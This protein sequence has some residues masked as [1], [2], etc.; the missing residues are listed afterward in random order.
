MRYLNLFILLFPLSADAD[1][2]EKTLDVV[3]FASGVVVSFVVHEVSHELTARA[4][5]EKLDWELNGFAT[6][7]YC[8]SPCEHI[9]KIAIAGNLSTAILGESLMYL[10]AKYKY[11][12][13]V[14]GMQ[15]YNVE[16][17]IGYAYRDSITPG[18]YGDY[19]YVDDRAQIALAIHA[20]SIGYRQFSKR[21]WSVVVVPRGL[22]FNVRF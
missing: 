14:D 7:S 18:G 6:K 15:A 17:P 8:R 21:F 5:G 12:P 1:W 4:Y 20:A 19:R 10:P 3:L 16:N 11:T 9:D 2:K 13:F 22:Q